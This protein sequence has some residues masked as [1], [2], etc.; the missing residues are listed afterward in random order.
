MRLCIFFF[1]TDRTFHPNSTCYL[2]VHFLLISLSF[3]LSCTSSLSQRESK[4][5]FSSPE[6]GKTLYILIRSA[7]SFIFLFVPFSYLFHFLILFIYLKRNWE[8]F[9]NIRKMHIH[10]FLLNGKNFSF[11]C[12]QP[13][14]R[15]FLFIPPFHLCPFLLVLPLLFEKNRKT[16]FHFFFIERTYL[17]LLFTFLFVSLL[18]SFFYSKKIERQFLKNIQK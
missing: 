2:V 3:T 16:I 15:T 5:D 10:F 4:N 13:F 8:R 6:F 9:F 17:M 7:F 18:S 1:W 12:D 11:W 14:W